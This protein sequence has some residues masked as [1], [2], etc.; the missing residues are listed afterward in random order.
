MAVGSAEIQACT[1][2]FNFIFAPFKILFGGVSLLPTT[3]PTDEPS[4]FLTLSL[5]LEELSKLAIDS[6]AADKE[7]WVRLRTSPELLE[8]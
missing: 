8:V 3:D 1:K 4:V 5:R 7:A 2:E 6:R